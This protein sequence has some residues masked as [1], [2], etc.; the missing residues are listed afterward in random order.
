MMKVLVV[1]FTQASTLIHYLMTNFKLTDIIPF[2]GS[3]FNYLL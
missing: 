2:N 1:T 3:E